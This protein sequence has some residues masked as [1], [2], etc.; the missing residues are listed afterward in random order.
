MHKHEAF[1]ANFKQLPGD[2]VTYAS[3]RIKGVESGFN[4]PRPAG[5]RGVIQY[6]IPVTGVLTYTMKGSSP[7]QF[8]GK[9][10]RFSN[11]N[12]LYFGK[13]ADGNF[14]LAIEILVPKAKP[15]PPQ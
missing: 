4:T 11:D 8:G 14:W 9:P 6:N 7:S 1:N 3:F 12:G 2:E 10:T 15:S 13:G 5:P